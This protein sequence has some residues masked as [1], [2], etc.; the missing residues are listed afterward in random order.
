MKGGKEEVVLHVLVTAIGVQNNQTKQG[1]CRRYAEGAVELGSKQEECRR[2]MQRG[3]WHILLPTRGVQ[4]DKMQKEEC[5]RNAD[6][7]GGARHQPKSLKCQPG[8][9]VESYNINC[10]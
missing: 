4:D 2:V 3:V 6:G 5:G 9:V 1:G 10:V 7:D 8:R